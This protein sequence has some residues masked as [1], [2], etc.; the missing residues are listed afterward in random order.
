MKIIKPSFEIIKYDHGA[1]K[2]LEEVGRTCYKSE[3]KITDT[4]GDKFINMLVER[5]HEAMIEHSFISVRFIHNRG[6]THELVRHR[7]VSYAQESTRYCNYAKDKFN[8]ELTFIEPFWFGGGDDT[9]ERS[10]HEL[11]LQIEKLYN[12][13]VNEGGLPPQAAR[14]ILPNDLKTEIV[15]SANVREWRSI[16]KLRCAR[17]AHPDMHRVMI[18][19]LYKLNEL[20]PV[21]FQDIANIIRYDE[22]SRF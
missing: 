3:D 2:F 15:A 18:P 7:L 13:F 16:F 17:G 21:L 12:V 11:M 20:L 22:Q 14:G 4:S 6:F 1:V 8:N 5:G 19:L 9:D 10:W